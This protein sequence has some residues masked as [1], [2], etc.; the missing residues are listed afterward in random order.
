[1]GVRMERFGR[2]W[3]KEPRPGPL[4]EKKFPEGRR[5]SAKR[6]KEYPSTDYRGGGGSFFLE[7]KGGGGDSA[8]TRI[9]K[10]KTTLFFRE[11]K[12]TSTWG[13]KKRT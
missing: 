8:P 10:G 5:T 4:W 1:M 13:E 7:K 11:R 6:G 2:R 3:N 12:G 9:K